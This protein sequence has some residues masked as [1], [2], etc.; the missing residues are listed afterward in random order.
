MPSPTCI[1]QTKELAT[2]TLDEE[3][4][5]AGSATVYVPADRRDRE[6]WDAE[7]VLSLRSNLDNHPGRIGSDRPAGR[8]HGSSS[9]VSDS[10]G[11]LGPIQLNRAGFPV[12]ADSKQNKLE[13]VPEED[14]SALEEEEED[15]T[16][17]IIPPSMLPQRQ[18]DETP[19]EKRS[20]KAAVKEAK[21]AARVAKKELKQMF[22]EER[23]KAARRSA[24][25]QPQAALHLP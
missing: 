10:A 5:K 9:S 21:R 20:R 19:E 17:E 8:R 14:D 2:A 1:L 12:A 25:A 16:I 18:K 11:S 6:R 15:E 22:K 3:D 4:E 24:T 7:S 23:G 13:H